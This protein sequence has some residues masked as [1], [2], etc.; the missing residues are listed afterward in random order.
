[1]EQ[2]Q[3][4]PPFLPAAALLQQRE[5]AQVG[6]LGIGALEARGAMLPEVLAALPCSGCPPVLGPARLACGELA[7]ENGEMM[8]ANALA[9]R[10]LTG[11]LQGN[12]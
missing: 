4:P 7:P 12:R 10:H 8:Q 11:R 5:M 1:M 3:D 9:C 2:L 6:P